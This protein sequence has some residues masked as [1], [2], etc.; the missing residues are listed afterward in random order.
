MNDKLPYPEH[1]AR[2]YPP[3]TK[4]DRRRIKSCSNP[5]AWYRNK[6][7][8]II[9]VHY[10]ATFGCWDTEGRWLDY[11]DL[12]APVVSS[13]KNKYTKGYIFHLIIWR[14]LIPVI[15]FLVGL[16]IALKYIK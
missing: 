9:T 8:H 10:F 5:K 2:G 12:S 7:G 16:F 6:I 15:M 14:I 11:Y 3:G 1:L 4:P 13:D